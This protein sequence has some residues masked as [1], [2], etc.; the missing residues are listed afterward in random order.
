M[1]LRL[2]DSKGIQP[3]PLIPRGSLLNMQTKTEDCSLEKALK[4]DVEPVVMV[5]VLI[6]PKYYAAYYILLPDFTLLVFCVV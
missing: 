5:V 3:M 1:T 6:E 4:Q 2:G